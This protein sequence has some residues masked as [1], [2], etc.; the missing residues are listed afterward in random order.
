[1]V[2]TVTSEQ[3]LSIWVPLQWSLHDLPVSVWALSGNPFQSND[4]I[5]LTGDF[6]STTE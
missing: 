2:S 4:A 6:K 3:D 1:M 5:T